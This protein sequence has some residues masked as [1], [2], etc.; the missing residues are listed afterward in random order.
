MLAIMKATQ[1]ETD[2]LLSIILNNLYPD[3]NVTLLKRNTK[4][5]SVGLN[6]TGLQVHVDL[7]EDHWAFTQE[8]EPLRFKTRIRHLDTEHSEVL[9]IDCD[10]INDRVVATCI[11][12]DD[13]VAIRDM[14]NNREHYGKQ[15]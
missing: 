6:A 15:S 7:P 14:M 10:G 12:T 9:V 1:I 4:F 5:G 3:G 11:R 8:E 13:A 2:R